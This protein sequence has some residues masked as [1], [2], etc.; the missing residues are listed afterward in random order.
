LIKL[1]MKNWFYCKTR[2]LNRS[3]TFCKSHT[4][5]WRE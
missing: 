2:Q 5:I 4:T 3:T 1:I